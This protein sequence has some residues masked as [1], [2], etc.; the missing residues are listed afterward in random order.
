VDRQP[1]AT[2]G[3]LI[4]ALKMT[5]PGTQLRQS[6]DNI[7]RAR[8]GALLVFADEEKIR[9]MISGGIDIDVALRR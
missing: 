7:V 5:A 9:P 1:L 8:T 3:R 6:I 2:Q 4:E